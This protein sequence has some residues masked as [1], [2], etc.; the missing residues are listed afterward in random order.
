MA[1]SVAGVA[2]YGAFASKMLTLRLKRTPG[3]LLPILGGLVF[4][5]FVLAWTL[6]SLWWF[7]TVGFT[8]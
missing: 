8:R 7:R 1:H 4:T 2:F 5:S 6:A 3:W